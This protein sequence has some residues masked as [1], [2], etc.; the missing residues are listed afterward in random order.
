[1][2]GFMMKCPTCG[3]QVSTTAKVCPHC[4]E[5]SFYQDLLAKS[6]NRVI[7]KDGRRVRELVSVDPRTGKVIILSSEEEK[8]NYSPLVPSE[9]EKGNILGAVIGLAALVAIAFVIGRAVGF[10]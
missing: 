2:S 4:G 7:L 6:S 10:W 8:G 9:E 3:G 1:M 5:T